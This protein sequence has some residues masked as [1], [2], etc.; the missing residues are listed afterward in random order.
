MFEISVRSFGV[1]TIFGDL[2]FQKL[3]LV[4]QNGVTIGI[5]GHW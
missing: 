2:V 4:E 3:S 5:R 1:F